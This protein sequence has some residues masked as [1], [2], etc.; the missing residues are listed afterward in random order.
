MYR[1]LNESP[2]VVLEINQIEIIKNTILPMFEDPNYHEFY[3]SKK[4]KSFKYWA[5]IVNLYYNGYHLLPEGKILINNIKAQINKYTTGSDYITEN[6]FEKELSEIYNITPPYEI[7]NGIR[8]IAGTDK[9]VSEKIN[10]KVIDDKVRF[11]IFL[12]GPKGSK[13][14]RG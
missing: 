8:F 5:I 3:I 14:A 10:V 4:W 9:L 7:K 2:V 12:P 13:R 1:G 6:N 11:Y